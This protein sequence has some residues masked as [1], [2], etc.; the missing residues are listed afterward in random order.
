[1]AT[2]ETPWCGG[3][4]NK[5]YNTSGQFTS[6][7][8]D[9][10]DVS[11]VDADP[12]S[13]E[14]DGENSAW[15]GRAD[16]KL[17]L[18]SGKF[19]STL[20]TSQAVGGIDTQAYGISWDGTNTPWCGA[21]G[22]KL[23]YMSSQFASTMKTSE[24]V[25]AV[26]TSP[27]GIS[28]DAV[29]TPWVGNAANKLYLTSGIYTSTLK[30]SE[31]VTAIDTTPSGI[32]WDGTN[33]P[34]CGSG[35]DKLYLQSGRFN[36]TLTTSQSVGT[37]DTFPSGISTDDYAG[38]VPS[39]APPTAPTWAV[40]TSN[41]IAT[42]AYAN[43]EVDLTWD[44]ASHATASIG[45][46]VQRRLTVGPGAW[47]EV[48]R[49]T[50]TTFTVS[51]GTNGTSYDF[52]VLA[53]ARVTTEPSQTPI[54]TATATPTY[55]D[56]PLWGGGTVSG[57]AAVDT[58][59]DGELSVSWNAAAQGQALGIGYIVEYRTSAVAPAP[60]GAWTEAFWTN[61]VSG[62]ITGLTNGTS[63]DVRVKTYTRVGSEPTTTGTDTATATP[64]SSAP[65][66]PTVPTI[67]GATV[68][69]LVVTVTISG[70]AGGS[71][72]VRLM[73]GADT[74]EDE[75]GR[76]GSGTVILTALGTGLRYLVAWGVAGIYHTEP[77]DVFIIIIP[78]TSVSDVA[79]YRVIMIEQIPGTP[80]KQITLERIE[81]PISP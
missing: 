30:D 67:T 16:D 66:L 60:A 1:M 17:Y 57:I 81:R 39:S 28:T 55:G 9:S 44:A 69:G 62:T 45:Y 52:R 19:A 27:L 31:S 72:R 37:V 6:T 75:D 24:D 53:Y 25:T 7:L 61:A 10:E 80:Y 35:G 43:S 33:T 58:V 26:D 29:D 59:T 50:A 68:D 56:A 70:D 34:W 4:D 38:R 79:H 12:S 63:Y 76:V 36:S 73:D 23:Y 51:N 40:N 5:L 71:Y 49:T 77:T 11:G 32:S 2:T 74:E 47:G 46:I 78:D 41:I 20:K 15:S 54:D 3:T 42:D 14:W 65:T 22:S 13:I 8:K 48:G 64:T 18:E 21:T